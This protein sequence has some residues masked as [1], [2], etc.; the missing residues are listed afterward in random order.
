MSF[1]SGI[2]DLLKQYSGGTTASGAVE[3]HFDEVAK[4]VPCSSVAGG[5]AEAFRSG[6]TAPFSQ[7]ATQ[8]F[9]NSS[10]AQQS[11]MLNTILATAGPAILGGFM[12]SHSGGVLGSLLQG[13]K[14]SLT[15]EEAATVPPEEVQNLAAH[16]EKHDGSIIDKLSE[17]YAGHP[18]LIKS[19]GVA[20]LGI[21]MRKMSETHN[22]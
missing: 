3:D 7:M 5:L 22:A 17:I 20:A 15:P 2:S 8:L 18:T 14:T 12:G 11:S 16:V 6:D 10:G 1:L 19:L 4:N 13:G 9:S 21:A